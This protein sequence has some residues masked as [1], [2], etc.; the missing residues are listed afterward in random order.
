MVLAADDS[1]AAHLARIAWYQV[2]LLPLGAAAW[3]FRSR[4]AA[5]A[6]LLAGAASILFWHSHRWIVARMLTPSVRLRWV[7]GFLVVVKLALLALILRGIMDFFPLEVLPTVTGILLFSASIMLE[8][9]Y[10]IFQPGS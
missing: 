5:L 10:L 9:I 8:A 3:L 2:G 1:G 6:F 4:P 7:F